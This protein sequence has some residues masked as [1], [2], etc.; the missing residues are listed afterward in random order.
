MYLNPKRGREMTW[1][2]MKVQSGEVAR[3]EEAVASARTR[4]DGQ[5]YEIEKR[6]PHMNWTKMF[7]VRVGC[8]L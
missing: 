8:H 6:R 1:S 4:W 3:G 5:D 7:R 2:R